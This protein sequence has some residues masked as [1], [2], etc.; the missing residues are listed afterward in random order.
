MSSPTVPLRSERIERARTIVRELEK[1]AVL[2]VYGSDTVEQIAEAR[3]ILRLT[4]GLRRK[5]DAYRR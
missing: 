2:E 4:I 1:Y 3:N 5:L